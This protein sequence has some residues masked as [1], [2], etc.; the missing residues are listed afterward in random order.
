MKKRIYH[1]KIAFL[2]SVS[3]LCSLFTSCGS[4]GVRYS[5]DTVFAMD[6]FIEIRAEGASGAVFD[7]IRNGIYDDERVFS[8]TSATSELY[9]LNAS[10]D[11]RAVSAPLAEV[12]GTALEVAETTDG[13]F[14]PCIGALCEL[15]DIKAENPEV[16]AEEKI[17]EAM[18]HSDCRLV[19]LSDGYLKKEDSRLHID[20]GGA[21]KG[22]SAGNVMAILREN[23]VENALVRFGGSV[24][25]LGSADGDG[26][27]WR[28][29]IKNPFC[30]DEIVGS[31]TMYDEYLAVSGSY[32]RYFEK[33]G[34]RYHHILD[35]KT[36]YPAE[37]DIEST[38]VLSK[39]GT[40]SDILSTALFVMG[41]EKAMELYNSG[42]YNFEAVFILKDGSVKITSGLL[43][44]FDFNENASFS[45]GGCLVFG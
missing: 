45:G 6:T 2:L 25:C 9:S 30:T 3:L 36:G 14:D 18:Q 35:A 12:L 38:A 5:T 34:I 33:D 29:G 7:A 4:F 31:V 26:N 13:A 20:L 41:T 40:L 17:A 43:G 16:P 27:G 15:W 8:R 24:A 32:E 19:S 28:V 1:R 11:G 10:P 39:D 42:K 21:A 23:G 44:G 22:Y 37:S